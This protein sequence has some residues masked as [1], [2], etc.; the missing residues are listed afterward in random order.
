MKAQI[1]IEVS[2]TDKNGIKEYSDYELNS[3]FVPVNDIDR[4]LVPQLISF[5]NDFEH[6]I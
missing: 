6:R 2:V 4:D 3:A 5:N 1:F